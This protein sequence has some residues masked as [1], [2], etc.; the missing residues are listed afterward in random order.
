M[1]SLIALA[2]F[3]PAVALAAPQT[4]E[5]AG[6]MK[7]VSD[8]PLE[9]IVGTASG[10]GALTV[11]L[12]DM[13]TLQATITVPVASMKTGND[14]RDDH[15]RSPEWLDAAQFAEITFVASAAKVTKPTTGDDVKEAEVEVTGKFTL[16][17][18]S[19]DMTAP[20]TLKWK[21]DKLKITTKFQVKLD[22]YN[23]KGRDG[24]VGS[25]VG[26]NID[27]DVSLKGVLKPVAP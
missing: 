9:K 16:H 3:A 1:R 2:L 18:V 14:Q 8:A 20:A 6:E 24:V 5:L 7:F 21:G 19:T 23:I 17:G 22:A 26:T 25:K 13:T 11:D 12:D 15:L 27:V 4:A 10:A